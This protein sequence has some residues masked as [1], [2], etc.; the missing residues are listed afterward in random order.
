MEE[1]RVRRQQTLQAPVELRFKAVNIPQTV[2]ITD[3]IQVAGVLHAVTSRITRIVRLGKNEGWEHA[4]QGQPHCRRRFPPL[5]YGDPVGM[6]TTVF[7]P[8]CAR[9][10]ADNQGAGG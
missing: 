3:A 6:E 4:P 2:T 7:Q 10:S 5:Y 9:T 8:S 1:K